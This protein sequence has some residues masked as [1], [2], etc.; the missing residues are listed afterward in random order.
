MKKA[1]GPLLLVCF[2]VAVGRMF[3]GGP[4]VAGA[5]GGQAKECASKNG[6]VNADGKVELS[7]AVT[8]LWH[9]FLG[10]PTKLVGLCL[11][12]PLHRQ[13]RRHGDGQLHGA[14]VAEEHGGCER[15]WE[16]DGSGI[17]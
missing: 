12:G 7:D 1:I 15:G 9:L 14:H 8:I 13:R 2:G 5:G 10:S 17:R 4:A 6:D 11:G 16:V 3:D